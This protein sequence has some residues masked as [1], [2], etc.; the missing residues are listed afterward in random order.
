MGMAAVPIDEFI[1]AIKRDFQLLFLSR[2]LNII[3]SKE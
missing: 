1:A 3:E 2:V